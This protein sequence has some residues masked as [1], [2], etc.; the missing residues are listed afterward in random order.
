M[1]AKELKVPVVD[2]DPCVVGAWRSVTKRDSPRPIRLNA[3]RK[4][5]WRGPKR[6]WTKPA[7]KRRRLASASSSFTCQTALPPKG[8]SQTGEPVWPR[9]AA[10]TYSFAP[11]PITGPSSLVRGRP[12]PTHQYFRPRGGSRLHLFPWHRRQGSHVPCRSLIKLRVAAGV[13]VV[14][15]TMEVLKPCLDGALPVVGNRRI[16]N[17]DELECERDCTSEKTLC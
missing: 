9:S 5:Q 7:S 13:F 17:Y 8:S 4:R 3:T 6:F 15:L 2:R 10:M 11:S 14:A 16:R 1:L 12:S